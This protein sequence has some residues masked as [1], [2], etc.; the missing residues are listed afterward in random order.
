MRGLS[1]RVISRVG[2]LFPDSTHIK[3]VGLREAGAHARGPGG[4]RAS[5]VGGLRACCDRLVAVSQPVSGGSVC[6]LPDW[7]PI[8]AVF[9]CSESRP[10]R[11]RP[12]L[13]ANRD[14]VA[15]CRRNTG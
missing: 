5:D 12:R 9:H 6:F 11:Q 3:A 1:D 2:D 14:T 7:F 10:Y 13:A 15:L 8:L 4:D